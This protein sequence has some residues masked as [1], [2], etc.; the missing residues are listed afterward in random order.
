VLEA[1]VSTDEPIASTSNDT[2]AVLWFL[3]FTRIL[4]SCGTIT[5][6][7][8]ASHPCP[9]EPGVWWKTLVAQCLRH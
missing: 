3:R 9:W 6:S 4:W 2:V 1:T 7:G 8:R 5:G